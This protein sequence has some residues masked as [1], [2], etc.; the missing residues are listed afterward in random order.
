M[1]NNSNFRPPRKDGF[2]P[3]KNFREE[4]TKEGFR[5][6]NH[7]RAPQVR[8]ISDDGEMIGIMTVPEALKVAE[9]KGL[10]LIE[11]APNANPPTCKVM[12]YGKYK[13]EQKKKEQQ[14]KKNQVIIDVKEL[15][16]RPGTEQHDLET[17]LRHAKRFLEDGDKVKFNMRFKGREMAHQDIGRKLLERILEQLKG[18]GIVE[19][20]P[21]NEG[22]QLFCLIAP[23]PA[24]LKEVQ[25]R[26][27]KEQAKQSESKESAE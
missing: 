21:K 5:M 6:N 13:Y 22:R 4:R 17:K 15:Q 2:A 26:K 11:V 16:L 18:I 19:V 25:A 23:D 1:N 10:D 20:A 27:K 3:K 9:A 12:D 7:I 14:S 8:V 24:F